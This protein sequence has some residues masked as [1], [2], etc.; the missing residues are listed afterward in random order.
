M[1]WR[2]PNRAGTSKSVDRRRVPT[3][4]DHVDDEVGAGE[5][6]AAV[7]FGAHG[8]RSAVAL[9]GDP[10]QPFGEL[11]AMRIDVVHDELERPEI[12]V[13]E[14]VTQQLA[15]E[16]CRAGADEAHGGHR[17]RM[18]GVRQPSNTEHYP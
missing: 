7:G 13:V 6:C 17:S 15:G 14:Q 1:V 12:G 16:D 5:G 11:E 8:R 18:A 3:D 10:G 2:R 9:E 4:V